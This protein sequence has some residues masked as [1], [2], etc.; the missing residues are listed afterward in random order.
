MPLEG[1]S[2]F[3]LRPMPDFF[4]LEIGPW[5]TMMKEKLDVNETADR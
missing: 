2:I 3:R 1:R 4:L 5:K